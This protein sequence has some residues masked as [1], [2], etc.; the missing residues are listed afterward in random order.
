MS[1]SWFWVLVVVWLISVLIWGACG[2]LS[3]QSFQPTSIT[4]WLD[5]HSGSVQAVSA[6]LIVLLTLALVLLVIACATFK[7]T[8][9][10]MCSDVS[11]TIAQDQAKF[12]RATQRAIHQR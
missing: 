11:S 6:G 8:C 2:L 1:K 5:K 9:A 3:I 7:K 12:L 10:S 4:Q